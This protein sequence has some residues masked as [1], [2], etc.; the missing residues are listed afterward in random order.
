MK[1]SLEE[2]R[3]VAVLARLQLS[4]A[5]AETL[6]TELENILTYIDKVRAVDVEGVPPTT[7]A[8]PMDCPLRVDSVGTQLSQDAALAN[9]PRR[10]ESYFAVP[11]IVADAGEGPEGM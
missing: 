11:K 5:E 1:I 10:E 8:V 3:E 9:A 6:R 7:H 4:D 2:V